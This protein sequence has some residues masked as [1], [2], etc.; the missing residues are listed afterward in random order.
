MAA[1]ITAGLPIPKQISVRIAQ[2]KPGIV[3]DK[4]IGILKKLSAFLFNPITIP[5]ILDNKNVDNN[6]IDNLVKVIP[7]LFIK[8][9]FLIILINSKR[10]LWIFGRYE[11]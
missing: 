9:P 1:I 7:A 5:K 2:T 3:R 6:E 4:R 8:E 11:I 10:I